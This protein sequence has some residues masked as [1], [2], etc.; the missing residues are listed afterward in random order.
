MQLPPSLPDSAATA[1][2]VRPWQSLSLRFTV[3]L[4][5]LLLL[6][7]WA[8]AWYAATALQHD[9]EELLG[10][11]QSATVDMLAAQVDE[12][13]ALRQR[14]LLAVASATALATVEG[15][16]AVQA[17]LQSLPLLLQLFNGGVA[18]FTAQGQRLAAHPASLAG[19]LV[20]GPAAQAAVAQVLRTGLPAVGG[21]DDH[22]QRHEPAF[23]QVVPVRNAQG[24]IVAVLA[25]VTQL[26]PQSFLDQITATA[27]G[28][29]AV[30]MLVSRSTRQVI[31]ATDRSRVLQ[32]LPAAGVSP[33]LDRFISGYQGYAVGRNALGVEV[34]ASASGVGRD[35]GWYVAVA[36]PTREAF[37]PV[38]RLRARVAGTTL[39]LTA[40]AGILTWWL[41]RRQ[42]SPM[43]A[44]ARTLSAYNAGQGPAPAL[45]VARHDEVGQLIGSFNRLVQVLA[46]REQALRIAA[47]A[48]ESQEGMLV[49][50]AQRRILRVNRAFTVITGYAA[51]EVQGRVS[52]MT[53]SRRHPDDFWDALWHDVEHTGAW[54]GEVWNRRKNGEEYL[55]SPE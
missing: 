49:L 43:L 11:Q 31:A 23:S 4:L 18:V 28:S 55:G 10:Q 42:L 16:A 40:L 33:L 5:A 36:I 46:A 35:A 12:A 45:H 47:I 32:T 8:L 24:R 2:T 25:G 3:S 17:K 52:G 7:L 50:D 21:A 41:V 13:L 22:G 27:H 26:A 15:E 9:I 37:A 30:Y 14:A 1:F 6:G 53:R 29:N 39:V 20:S 48:F 54:Q 38:H 51:E 34:L 19:P 44:A